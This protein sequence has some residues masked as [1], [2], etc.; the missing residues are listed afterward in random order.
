MRI[1]KVCTG[2]NTLASSISNRRSH[3]RATFHGFRMKGKANETSS[4]LQKV[5]GGHY[6]YLGLEVFHATKWLFQLL[7]VSVGSEMM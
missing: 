3:R 1:Y 2:P 6:T 5:M 7:V 4:M